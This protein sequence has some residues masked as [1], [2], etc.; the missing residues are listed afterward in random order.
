MILSA[1]WITCRAWAERTQCASRCRTRSRSE[2]P[3]HPSSSAIGD[4]ETSRRCGREP[5]CNCIDHIL[6]ALNPH[7]IHL[8]RHA[9]FFFGGE[10]KFDQGKRVNA[11]VAQRGGRR[12]LACVNI[13]AVFDQP[14]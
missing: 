12:K 14:C 6:H 4:P 9:E 7:L 11:K 10:Y 1:I 13:S 2:E 5:C 8:Y 3:L